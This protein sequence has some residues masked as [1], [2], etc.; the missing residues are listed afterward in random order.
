MI[1]NKRYFTT[2]KYPKLFIISTKNNYLSIIK[3][4][5]DADQEFIISIKNNYLSI[6]KTTY[7]H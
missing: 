6:L 3:T 5:Y 4:D 7:K 2:Y 1:Q